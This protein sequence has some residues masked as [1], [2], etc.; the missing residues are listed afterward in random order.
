MND[1][2]LLERN[3]EAVFAL[4]DAD[5]DG[6]V[7]SGDF[8]AIGTRICEQLHITGSPQAAAML[9]GYASAWEQ[10]RADCDADGDGRISPAEFARA[11]LSASGG[12]QAYFSRHLAA[13]TSLFADAMDADGDGFIE[14]AEYLAFFGAAP[15]L[16]PGAAQA[17]FAR[18]DAD[19]DG[20][21]SRGEFTA[22]VAQF[23]LSSDPAHPGTGILGQA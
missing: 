15:D 1:P 11:L 12:P 4:Y 7:T 16:D 19:G 23:F 9:E 18:L 22:G 6:F 20:R 14:P 10:L 21:V 17:A 13:L 2:S 3:L 5:A 8:T